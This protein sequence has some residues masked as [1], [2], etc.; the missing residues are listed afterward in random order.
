MVS[1]AADE[2]RPS[3][4]SKHLPS[5]E[6]VGVNG[7]SVSGCNVGPLWSFAVEIQV[8]AMSDQKL[9]IVCYLRN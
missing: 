8:N 7:L 9:N 2:W 1:V 5:A 6:M 3:G 4:G